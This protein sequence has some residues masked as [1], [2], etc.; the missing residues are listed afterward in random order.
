[1]KGFKKKGKAVDLDQD[2]QSQE[3]AQGKVLASSWIKRNSRKL[4]ITAG[5][6]LLAGSLLLVGQ[7]YVEANKVPFYRVYLDG[8][9]IGTIKDKKELTALYEKKQEEFAK[10]Y[11]G[12]NMV[13]ETEGVSTVLDKAYKA[14][15]DGH[16][17][18]A[19]LDKQLKS[20]ASGV[21]L[22]VDG[23][24]IGVVK[25]Q[26]TAE[27]VLK[28]VKNKYIPAGEQ[29]TLESKVKK[30]STSSSKAA[31]AASS[32]KLESAV[33]KEKIEQAAVETTPDKVLDTKAA[34]ARILQGEVTPIVYEVQE[35]D[36]ITSIAKRFGV[37]YKSIFH[38]NPGV[39]ERTMQ[40]GTQLTIK[41]AKPS[42]TVK[43]VE[44]VQEQIVTEPTVIVRKNAKLKAGKTIVA[45]QGQS[46]L[47][48]MSYRVTK[49]NGQVIQEEW[50][51]QEVVKQPQPRIVVKG[52][53]VLGEGSGQF[54]WPLSSA[55]M[56]SSYGQRW[57]KLHKGVDLV[58]SNRTIMAADAGVVTFAGTKSGYGNVIIIDHKNGYETLYGHLSK[59]TV[60]QGAKV[61]KG[62]S[63]GVMG[64]TGRST[65][66]HLHFE[67]HKGGQLQNPMKYL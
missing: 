7:Q 43:T 8:Q 34:V 21:A 50:L 4:W 24:V 13:L 23:K 17:A 9:E 20:H 18:I 19:K 2:L 58:S 67:I 5:G 42:L 51:G 39:E 56:S 30:V 6:V 10:K 46:G 3:A 40:I 31:T 41:A 63:I 14:E 15:V 28:Q 35:G 52:T 48:T 27:A 60:K 26:A 59:I 37:S 38:Q 29:T 64:S 33:I 57:G 22:K 65:G 25:D 32:P 12:A 53:L 66:P 55:S 44:R 61:Q 36:T 11:P 1:M 16:T 45:S 49:E 47:K 62:A 54:A